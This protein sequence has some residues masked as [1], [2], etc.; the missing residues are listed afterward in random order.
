Y[1]LQL[2]VTT[3]DEFVQYVKNVAGEKGLGECENDSATG[4]GVV[5]VRFR[6]KKDMEKWA[7]DFGGNVELALDQRSIEQNEF[8]D[9][10][11]VNDASS[12]RKQLEEE[13]EE[14]ETRPRVA[15]ARDDSSRQ[16]AAERHQTYAR[17]QA[18]NL[19]LQKD[20]S[21]SSNPISSSQPS[22][23]KKKARRTIIQSRFK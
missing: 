1:E 11:L 9:A 6:G 19:V 16:E 21:A 8:L 12:L 3:V 4:K 14:E 20:A 2:G 15:P 22:A 13:D 23:A 5:V 7:A 10:I 18:S 17:D